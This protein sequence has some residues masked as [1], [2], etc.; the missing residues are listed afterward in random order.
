VKALRRKCPT[1]RHVHDTAGDP[2][3]R[4]RPAGFEGLARI[5]VGQQLSVASASAIWERTVAAC[6]PFE[7]GSLL[8]LGDGRLAQA[9]LSRVVVL[10]KRYPMYGGS[11]RN[12]GGVRAQ[13][14][15]LANLELAR[16]SIPL[17]RGVAQELGLHTWFRQSGY[18]MLARD[19]AML[20]AMRERARFQRAHGVATT[21]LSRDEASDLAPAVDTARYVGASYCPDDAVIFPWPVVNG[22]RE[23]CERLGVEVHTRTPVTGFSC[24]RGR[25]VEARTPQARFRPGWVV[26]AAGE[27]SAEVARLAGV[28]LPNRP[29]R[30]QIFVTEAL[31]PMLDPMVVDMA[32]GL[33]VSQDGRGELVAGLGDRAELAEVTTASSLEFLARVARGLVELMPSVGAVHAMRQWAGTY[34]MT[35][36]HVP[37]L[38]P[39]PELGNFLQLNGFSGHGFM[40][41]PVVTRVTARIVLGREPGLDLGRYVSDRFDR[42]TAEPE[43]MVV[44]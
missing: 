30:H 9:G 5:I 35:P 28:G 37:N 6:R 40:V 32:T 16:D 7:P 11:G 13:W 31:R 25:I 44:G 29:V 2:P 26:N 24:E 23:A 1:M 4:R 27:W 38:G 17:W 36:D 33:Y 19:G 22:L 43:A 21:I 14:A 42:G 18:L 3:L 15:S 12:G 39:H 10:E 8:A 41:S 20:A 34:D